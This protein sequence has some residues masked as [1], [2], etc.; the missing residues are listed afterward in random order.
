M[1]HDGDFYYGP[2]D[3]DKRTMVKYQEV[4]GMIDGSGRGTDETSLTIVAYINGWLFLLYQF[5]T[6]DGY[7]TDTLKEI[8]RR[9]R[10]TSRSSALEANFGDGMF[11]ALLQPV[12]WP[13]G[14]GT[15]RSSRMTS[16][17]ALALRKSRAA[18]RPR[19]R[20]AS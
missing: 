16:T 3:V 1:G 10:S 17:A 20:S 13:S 7:G 5:S 12:L 11:T 6:Q 2:V 14:G 18:I 9:V 19:R 4:A 15:T 8:A